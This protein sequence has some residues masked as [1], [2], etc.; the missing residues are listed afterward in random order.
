[1]A[2]HEQC[3][4]RM[5]VA[6]D[7]PTGMLTMEVRCRMRVGHQGEHATDLTR[8][9]LRWPAHPYPDGVPCES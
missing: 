8:V 1:M 2:Y 7:T 4:E 3:E 9:L 5:S 6:L